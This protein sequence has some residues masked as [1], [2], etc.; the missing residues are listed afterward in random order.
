MTQLSTLY[1]STSPYPIRGSW[2]YKSIVLLCITQYT[3][4]RIL[5]TGLCRVALGLAVG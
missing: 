5:K 1:L 4:Q 2:Q 3:V